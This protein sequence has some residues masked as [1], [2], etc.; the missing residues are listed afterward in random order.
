MSKILRALLFKSELK[1]LT[2]NRLPDGNLNKRTQPPIQK[3]ASKVNIDLDPIE[4][5]ED[6][7]K[8]PTNLTKSIK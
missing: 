5:E 3:L 2:I 6:L 7:T 1:A 4:V 8:L